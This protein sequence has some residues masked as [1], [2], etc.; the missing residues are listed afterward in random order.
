MRYKVNIQKSH[1]FLYISNKQVEIEKKFKT[2]FTIAPEN[3]EYLGRNLTTCVQDLY[4]ENCNTLVKEIKDS[5][6]HGVIYHVHELDSRLNKV[7]PASIY[8]FNAVVS[9][10]PSDFF[11][12]RN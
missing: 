7:L 4:A 12:G 3:M 11:F 2:S 8:K 1:L 10:I 5:G 9:T 6:K